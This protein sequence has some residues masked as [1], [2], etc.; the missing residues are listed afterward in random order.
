MKEQESIAPFLCV[1]P[2]EG[3]DLVDVNNAELVG[4]MWG[5]TDK[6]ALV[7]DGSGNGFILRVGDRVQNGRVVNPPHA[8]R[9][10]LVDIAS[11]TIGE[12]MSSSNQG[13]VLRS[14]FATEVHRYRFHTISVPDDVDV[15]TNPLAFDPVQ[16]RA[17]FDAGYDLGR[18]GAPAWSDKP[19]I[20]GDFPPWALDII[21]D[22]L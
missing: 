5:P 14:Y 11:T 12:M 18:R 20:L 9:P 8:V 1:E 19:R 3:T 22:G 17:G 4:V 15:G 7:E 10:G 16:M 21:R 6:F 2:G 13:L